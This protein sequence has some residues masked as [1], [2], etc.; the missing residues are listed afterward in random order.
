MELGSE[1][2]FDSE[3]NPQRLSWFGKNGSSVFGLALC[4]GIKKDKNGV[5]KAS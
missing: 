3:Y 4:V 1:S 5:N 2:D